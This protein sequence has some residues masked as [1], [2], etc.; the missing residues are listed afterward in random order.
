[1]L[2]HIAEE[3]GGITPTRAKETSREVMDTKIKLVDTK[4]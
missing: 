2:I 3:E 4:K 1:M